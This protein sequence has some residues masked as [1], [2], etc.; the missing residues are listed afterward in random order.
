[1]FGSEKSKSPSRRWKGS[2]ESRLEELDRIS[3]LPDPLICNILSHLP[4]KDAVK[5][6]VCSARWR[7][8]WLWV[9][10]LELSSQSF[11][12]FKAFMSFGDRF[13]DSNRVSCINKVKLDIY[14]DGADLKSWIDATIKRKIQHL[15][16]RCTPC[17]DYEMPSSLYN[18]ETLVSLK[19]HE[20]RVSLVDFRFVSLPCV[21]TMHLKYIRYGNEAN[22]EASFKRLV[23]CCPVLEELKIFAY[24]WMSRRAQ[25]YRVVSRS[26]K[27]LRI[28]LEEDFETLGLGF[29]IDA[30]LLS[31]LSIKDSLSENFIINNMD[32]IAKVDLYGIFGLDDFGEASVV[33]SRGSRIRGF[34]LGIS[35]VRDM[36]ICRCT[37]KLICQ[38]SRFQPLPQFGY[39]SHLFVTLR[40]SDLKSLPTFL[41]SCPK[42]KS[43]ILVW[44][45]NSKKM[46]SDGDDLHN[47]IIHFASVPECLLSSLEFVDIKTCIS[48]HAPEMKVVEYFL[49]NSAILMKITLRLNYYDCANEKSFFKILMAIP[50]RS[51]TCEV[52]VL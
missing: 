30:P 37:F 24:E 15:H 28:K 9:P 1:M 35:K 48:G 20:V 41:E 40:V 23:S 34:L 29:V 7:S 11:S 46:H 21:K 52:V 39:M 3:Q 6:S 47:P 42:L 4:T 36:T 50:R 14:E 49:K 10:C 12:D 32:S 25:V 18:C 2:S 43:L 8:L 38:Y 26:L 51:A 5:T 16:V 22:L 19:L 44:D 17:T 31:C 45:G 27:K 13:F 33:T